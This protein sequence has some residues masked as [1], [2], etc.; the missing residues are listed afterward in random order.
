[1]S[2][3]GERL[4]FYFNALNAFDLKAVESMFAENAVYISSGL[5]S[6]KSG[7]AEIISSFKI[8][9]EEFADQISVDDNVK[10]I[11]H[12][13]FSSDWRLKATSVKT[14][15][16]LERVGTQVTTFN[17]HGLIARVKVRDAD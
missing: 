1:V 8:Y 16:L 11:G 2:E 9:F 13:T 6:T 7:R 4:R 12:N 5:K 17:E 3:L 15:R 10:L 14:G